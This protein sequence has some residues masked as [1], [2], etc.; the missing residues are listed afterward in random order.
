MLL[1]SGVESRRRGAVMRVHYGKA[2]TRCLEALVEDY[3]YWLVTERSLAASTV[4]YYVAGAGLFLSEVDEGDLKS[5]TVGEVTGFVVRHC[6][7][8]SVGNAKNL[9]TSLRSLLG[10]LYLQGLTDR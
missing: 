8:L 6:P 5:L 10:Y 7:R 2:L 1:S 3:R 4:K 9:A